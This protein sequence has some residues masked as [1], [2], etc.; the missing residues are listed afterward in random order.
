M[1]STSDKYLIP[2][3]ARLVRWLPACPDRGRTVRNT[4]LVGPPSYWLPRLLLS[5]AVV[6][7]AAEP[8]LWL[9]RTWQD[10]AYNSNGLLVFALALGLACWSLTSPL[11]RPAA[12]RSPLLPAVL[13]GVSAS[14]RLA[15]QVLAVNTIGAICLVIDVMAVCLILGLDRR[16]RA[17]SPFWLAAVFA[18]SL[19]L[20]RILQR[21]IGYALQ[22]VSADGACALLGLFYADLTC[23]GTR[24]ILAGRDV[25]VDL[26]C[27]GA[28]GLLLALL[29]FAVASALCRP[30]K[31]HAVAGAVVVVAAAIGANIVRIVILAV[32]IAQPERLGG[33]DVMASP[34]HDVIGLLTL[35][36][37]IAP[38]L[39]WSHWAFEPSPATLRLAQP[40][41]PHTRPPAFVP[42]RVASDGWWLN[43][44]TQL[45][46]DQPPVGGMPATGRPTSTL[47]AGALLLVAC[48]IVS[49]PRKPLDVGRRPPPLALPFVLAGHHVSPLPLTAREQ[50]YFTRFGGAGVKAAY[51]ENALMLIRTS[52]PLR[53]L[54]T[55]EDCLR[56]I[57]FEVRY[58][59]TRFEP[60]PTAVYD[61]AAPDGRRYR[62]AVT[63][64][65][66]SG[67]TT[68]NVATAVWRWMEGRA[69]QWTAVQRITPLEQ[70][71]HV[72]Q[73]FMRSVWAALELHRVARHNTG[74]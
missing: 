22:H 61:A 1:A 34:W 9:F 38:L 44:P 10:P 30:G 14:V 35:V 11:I 6:V 32:G 58:R 8:A 48:V 27:S 18:F 52:S 21:T 4:G 36:L 67:E 74:D 68:A 2:S 39:V 65:S 63:F 55:P 70:P 69:R 59:G 7:L 56:G 28:R 49:L 15:G 29:A 45:P 25:L 62:I 26:P 72:R 46:V 20:E 42:T 40:R 71:E 19:P 33:I 24:L 50:A 17:V 43:Q 31:R 66:D 37:A 16:A 47:A 73:S 3:L 5:A 60:V 54:H 12:A 23:N 41:P 57:G 13:L 53:H 51:G 64:V